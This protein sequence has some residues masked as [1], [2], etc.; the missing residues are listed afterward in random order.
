MNV[1]LLS[2]MRLVL[3][4]M[5]RG[6][7]PGV[8]YIQLHKDEILARYFEQNESVLKIARDLGVSDQTIYNRFHEWKIK[9][10]KVRRY[11]RR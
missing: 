1:S 3:T 10:K 2:Q 5:P 11:V 6:R 7:K 8:G 4:L 9:T